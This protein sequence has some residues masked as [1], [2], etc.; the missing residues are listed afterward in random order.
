MIINGEREM[1]SRAAG[2]R[3]EKKGYGRNGDAVKQRHNEKDIGARE[4]VKK[5]IAEEYRN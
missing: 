2:A 1:R 3:K 4:K 5:G